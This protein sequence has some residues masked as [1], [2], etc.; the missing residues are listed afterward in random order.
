ML[1]SKGK[2]TAFNPLGYQVFRLISIE[3]SNT[4]NNDTDNYKFH[5]STPIFDSFL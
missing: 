3:K 5:F 4:K 2:Q 1:E